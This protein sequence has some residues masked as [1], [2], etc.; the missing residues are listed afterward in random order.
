MSRYAYRNSRGYLMTMKARRSMTSHVKRPGISVRR[1]GLIVWLACCASISFVAAPAP[2]AASMT[3]ASA[4]AAVVTVAA[5]PGAGSNPGAN[6]DAVSCTSDG[7]CTAVGTYG[8]NLGMLAT[9]S[10]GVWQQ[11]QTSPNPNVKLTD[12]SCPDP[13]ACTTVGSDGAPV[14]VAQQDGAWQPAIHL[15]PPPDNTAGNIGLDSVS[16]A[17][18]G[19]CTAIGTYYTASSQAKAMEITETAGVWQAAT[20]LV[21][22]PD[23]APGGAMYADSVSCPSPGNC[24]VV[25]YY[26][27]VV[28]EQAVFAV[29]ETDG[30]WNQGTRIVLP[31]NAAPP[32]ST[33]ESANL[34]AVSCTTVTDCT[35]VGTYND[36]SGATDAM[37]VTEVGG[38][39]QQS[40]EMSAPPGQGSFPPFHDF[41]EL[42]AVSCATAGDCVATGDYSIYTGNASYNVAMVATET[43]GAWQQAVRVQT[44][45]PGPSGLD[46]VSCASTAGCSAVGGYDGQTSQTDQAMA[47]D[48]T[49]AGYWEVAS[50]GGIFSF[51]TLGSARFYGSMGGK[52]LNAPVVGM[53]ATPDGKGYWEVASDG[54][55]FAFGDAAFHGSMGGTALNA[56][57]V[58]LAATP[59]GGG[60]LEVASDGGVFAFGDASFYGSMGAKPLNA[61]IVGLAATLDG[62]G[63]WEVASDGGIFAFGSAQFYGS[64]GGTRLNR[65][66]VGLAPTAG[67]YWEVASDGGVFA[68]GAAPFLGS[69][70]GTPLDKPVVGIAA[71]SDGEGY[72]EVASDGGIFNFGSAAYLGSMGGSSLNKP[73]VGIASA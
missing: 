7:N 17:S 40:V 5:P 21:P 64:M 9:Q 26:G 4:S 10:Q 34:G 69:M 2:F 15:S 54:G 73:V 37:V 13:G 50:D 62:K 71:T 12:I 33:F 6:L 29:S 8:A 38:V 16:C 48:I 72:W 58:G 14:V 43:D 41:A 60:Y 18:A 27:A 49:P 51:G 23:A 66:I 53:A 55:I 28:N 70:G 52:P 44:P 57:V 47:A 20:A 39:W 25:G 32:A 46:G 1:S 11:A 24:T 68:F 45:E 65:P 61:P 63:Y 56:Q 67:G 19:N 30:T 3:A 36:A 59:D 22:P 42:D 31:A 35:A